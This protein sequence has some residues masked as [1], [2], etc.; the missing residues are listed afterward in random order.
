MYTSIIK[1]NFYNILLAIAIFFK[2]LVN[3][4][5][6]ITAFFNRAIRDYIVYIKQ[7]LRYKIGINLVC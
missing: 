6:F 4:M 1:S 3:H 5:N 2:W 7:L